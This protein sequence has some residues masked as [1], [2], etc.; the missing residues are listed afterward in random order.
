MGWTP[1]WY[2]QGEDVHTILDGKHGIKYSG[3]DLESMRAVAKAHKAR[4]LQDFERVLTEFRP[5]TWPGDART[6]S[7]RAV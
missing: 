4:S 3:V 6:R 7:L 1:P 2:D 5:R